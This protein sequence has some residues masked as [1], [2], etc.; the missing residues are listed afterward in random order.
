MYEDEQVAFRRIE[1]TIDGVVVK[2]KAKTDWK[3]ERAIQSRADIQKWITQLKEY[4]ENGS[5]VG[6]LQKYTEARAELASWLGSE[7]GKKALLA[8]KD[9][10]RW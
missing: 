1:E 2:D 3:R 5:L 7:Q 6:Q 8:L 9:V 10:E 4:W